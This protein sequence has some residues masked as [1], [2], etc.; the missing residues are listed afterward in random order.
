MITFNASPT[1]KPNN[2]SLR[3]RLA[4]SYFF[5]NGWACIHTADDA[6]IVTDESCDLE[7]SMVFPDE[8]AFVSW[9]EETCSSHLADDPVAFLQTFCSIPELIMPSVAEAMLLALEQT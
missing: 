8:E 3:A 5:E 7:R 1:T 4:W 6:W 2:L 9:L